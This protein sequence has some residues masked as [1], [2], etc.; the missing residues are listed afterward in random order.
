MQFRLTSWLLLYY[1][2][3]ICLICGFMFIYS[4]SSSC[5]SIFHQ[6]SAWGI[7]CNCGNTTQPAGPTLGLLMFSWSGSVVASSQ[8]NHSGLCDSWFQPPARKE[9][10]DLIQR[11]LMGIMLLDWREKRW[12]PLEFILEVWCFCLSLQLWGLEV[13]PRPLLATG[14]FCPSLLALLLRKAL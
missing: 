4:W 13:R 9:V 1:I 2:L 7:K 3:A 12:H 8:E 14:I 6:P 5:W 10:W 11:L